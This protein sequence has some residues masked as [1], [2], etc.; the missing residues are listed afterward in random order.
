[1]LRFY[2]FELCLTRHVGI[3]RRQ[4]KF[5]QGA[6]RCSQSPRSAHGKKTQSVRDIRRALL[7]QT[8]Q[9]LRQLTQPNKKHRQR[10]L[11]DLTKQIE[12]QPV[13]FGLAAD[14]EARFKRVVTQSLMASLEIPPNETYPSTHFES[15]GRHGVVE[16]IL[17]QGVAVLSGRI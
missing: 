8:L 1:M 3:A 14:V 9:R 13:T 16:V 12:T 2:R 15:P 5:A 10:I 6:G 4:L 11:D 7:V 17:P